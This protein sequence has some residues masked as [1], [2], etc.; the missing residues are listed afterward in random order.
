[1]KLFRIYRKQGGGSKLAA[2][3]GNLK[4]LLRAWGAPDHFCYETI[5]AW[6]EAVEI[7]ERLEFTDTSGALCVVRCMLS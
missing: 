1:M 3:E 6:L 4:D 5:P 7:G 2:N